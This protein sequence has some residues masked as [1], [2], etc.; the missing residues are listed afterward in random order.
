MSAAAS[1]LPHQEV[2]SD[3]ACDWTA[4]LLPEPEA[5]LQ[6]PPVLGLLACVVADGWPASEGWLLTDLMLLAVGQATSGN[7]RCLLQL[8]LPV[9]LSLSIA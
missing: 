8:T 3:T 1:M 4:A 5:V 7:M 6:P 2:V 9:P